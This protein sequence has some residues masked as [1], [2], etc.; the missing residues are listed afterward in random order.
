MVL[1]VVI[2]LEGAL[3][4]HLW[5]KEQIFTTSRGVWLNKA[6]TDGV[7]GYPK[8]GKALQRGGRGGRKA[9]GG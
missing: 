2:W 7:S 1:G 3:V 6:W 9:L 5:W 4:N 8:E